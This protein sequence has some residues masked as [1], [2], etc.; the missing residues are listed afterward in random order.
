[1][2]FAVLTLHRFQTLDMNRKVAHFIAGFIL[3]GLMGYLIVYWLGE[4]GDMSPLEF[5]LIWGL[6][7]ALAEVFVFERLRNRKKKE[8]E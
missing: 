6:L 1:M 2:F 8:K 7:M 4:G 5:A 3:Y